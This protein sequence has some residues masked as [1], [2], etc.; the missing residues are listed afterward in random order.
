MVRGLNRD[1]LARSLGEAWILTR[2]CSRKCSHSSRGVKKT[3]QQ[4]LFPSVQRRRSSMAQAWR[5]KASGRY[6]RLIP[7][8]KRWSCSVALSQHSEMGEYR[9]SAIHTSVILD[10]SHLR[11]LPCSIN[12]R[13]N[14]K[15]S[16]TGIPRGGQMRCCWRDMD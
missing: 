14:R 16:F 1:Q 9:Y 4:V 13:G 6:V 11:F 5:R 12:P 3:R 15:E 10:Q 7:Q 2:S 8:T